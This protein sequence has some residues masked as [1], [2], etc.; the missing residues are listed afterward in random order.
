MS[1]VSSPDDFQR[2]RAA[3]MDR[4][5][6]DLRAQILGYSEAI[7]PQYVTLMR[8][9]LSGNIAATIA[10]GLASRLMT[11]GL[12]IWRLPPDRAATFLDSLGGRDRRWQ[13]L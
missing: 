8:Q 6:S 3:R 12:P 13:R 2:R 10:E 9:Y 5:E 4:T 1:T 11:L 7:R